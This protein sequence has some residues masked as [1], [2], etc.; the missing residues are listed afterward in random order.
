MIEEE[1]DNG[2]RRELLIAGRGVCVTVILDE[3]D[4]R[5][6]HLHLHQIHLNKGSIL[7]LAS[8]SFSKS[9]LGNVFMD[10]RSAAPVY[11]EGLPSSILAFL[12]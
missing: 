11:E 3:A 10:A 9:F 2:R 8:V 12:A 1:K 5:K 7:C 4:R 6:E